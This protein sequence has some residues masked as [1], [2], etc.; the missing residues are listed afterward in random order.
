MSG[1]DSEAS[2]AARIWKLVRENTG[3]VG[4]LFELITQSIYAQLVAPGDIVVDGGAHLGRH[5]IPL[6]RLVGDGGRVLAFEPL[7]EVS[8]QLASLLAAH[9]L[10]GRVVLSSRALSRERGRATF[11]AVQ[12]NTEFSGLSKRTYGLPGFVPEHVEIPVELTTLDDAVAELA[13]GARV[14]FIKLDLEGGEFSALRGAAGVLQEHRCVCVFENGLAA[15]AA[16][17][18]YSQR[19]FFDFFRELDYRVHDVFGSPLS[20]QLWDTGGPWY[21][22]AIPRAA[23]ATIVPMVTLAALEQVLAR[24]WRPAPTE[25][26]PSLANRAPQGGG[27]VGYVDEISSWIRV[28]GWAGYATQGRAPRSLVCVV[29]GEPVARIGQ[30]VLRHDVVAQTCAPGLSHSGFDGWIRLPERLEAGRTIEVLAETAEG[31]FTR[32]AGSRD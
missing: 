29:D 5:T 6:A 10:G 19:E 11:Y 18:G 27:I 31:T 23:T 21:H 26:P 14:S 8:R 16:L 17:E 3:A 32:I 20:E 28:S 24:L 13:P 15:S 30:G 22:L 4:D 12:N 9:G 2:M 1:T 7:P 25:A